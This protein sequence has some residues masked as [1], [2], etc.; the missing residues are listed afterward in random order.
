M[1]RPDLVKARTTAFTLKVTVDGDRMS[2]FETTVVEIYGKSFE[3][4]DANTLV[5]SA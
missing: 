5:R 3:H 4:T 1:F 2:Y